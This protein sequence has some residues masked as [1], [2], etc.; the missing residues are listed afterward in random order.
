MGAEVSMPHVF[1]FLYGVDSG[2]RPDIS[3][4]LAVSLS[5]NVKE[6]DVKQENS[7]QVKALIT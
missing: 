7:L 1:I 6:S 5:G 2:V 4:R 3:L